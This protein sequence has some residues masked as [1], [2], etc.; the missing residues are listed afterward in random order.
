VK[1]R[2]E[3]KRDE[4]KRDETRRD[5]KTSPAETKQNKTRQDKKPSQDNEAGKREREKKFARVMWEANRE[6]ENAVYL[7]EGMRVGFLEEDLEKRGKQLHIHPGGWRGWGGKDR[8]KN[9]RIIWN[10]CYGSKDQ[11]NF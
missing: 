8:N 10:H 3:K 1:R 6:R 2:K 4:K 5:E 7:Q 9:I 11:R